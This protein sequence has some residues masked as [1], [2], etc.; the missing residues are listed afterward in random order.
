M[1]AKNHFQTT[2]LL[3]LVATCLFAGCDRSATED[4]QT[5]AQAARDALNIRTPDGSDRTVETERKVNV[6][7]ETTVVDRATGEVISAEK[8]VTPVTVTKQKEIETD[9]DVNVGE[10]VKTIE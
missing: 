10:A 7:Q 5:P 4:V 2:F 8:E 6:V 1:M 9:V 3:G